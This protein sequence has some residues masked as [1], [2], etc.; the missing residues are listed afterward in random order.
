MFRKI[1]PSGR[2]VT[3]PADG[4]DLNK[5]LQQPPQSWYQAILTK[6]V[7]GPQAVT[8]K[9]GM[10]V[11]WCFEVYCNNK[12]VYSTYRSGGNAQRENPGII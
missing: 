6:K 4:V 8:V 7:K 10:G 2:K 11:D 12:I 3:I 9:L 1:I 5:I